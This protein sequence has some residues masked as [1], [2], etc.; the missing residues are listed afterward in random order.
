MQGEEYDG[1]PVLTGGIVD[2]TTVER[3]Q[4]I[5]MDLV[6]ALKRHDTSPALYALGD[7]VV[8][9]AGMSMGDLSVTLIFEQQP[10]AISGYTQVLAD[11]PV[12][13]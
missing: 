1:I 13:R 8:A 10:K 2:G 6:D 11:T 7:G 12:A 4:A 3:A 9:I 5:G